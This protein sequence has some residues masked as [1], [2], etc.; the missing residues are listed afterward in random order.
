MIKI[1]GDSS[2]DTRPVDEAHLPVVKV[3]FSVI[4]DNETIVDTRDVDLVHFT[5]TMKESSKFQSACPSPNDFLEA[6]RGPENVFSITI[7]S[8]LSGSHNAAELAKKL[9]EEEGESQG[10]VV[11][12]DSKSASTGP[13]LIYRRLSELIDEGLSFEDIK[14]KIKGYEDTLHTMFIS[15]SLENLRKAG[16]LSNLKAMIVK[17]LNIVPIMGATDGVIEMFDKARGERK[18]FETLLNKME[19]MAG[20]LAGKIVAVSHA[21]YESKAK[22]VKA[23]I[24]ARFKAREVIILKMQALNTLYADHE[25]I[26]ISF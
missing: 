4:F 7:T 26:I 22:E 21:D 15:K 8:K 25:G 20:D 9:S 6:Y 11:V 12:I 19:E 10:E 3:P 14:E 16:R 17:A 24:E 2:L 1:V 13:Y 18:A 5:K 23:A